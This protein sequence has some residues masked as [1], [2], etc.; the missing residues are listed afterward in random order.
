LIAL[1]LQRLDKVGQFSALIVR[2]SQFLSHF[3]PQ[4]FLSLQGRFELH[5]A[6]G[7]LADR[8]EGLILVELD[9]GL[10]LAAGVTLGI[11]DLLRL[12][13]QV[14]HCLVHRVKLRDQVVYHTVLRLE[15]LIEVMQ[16]CL[17]IDR[18][19]ETHQLVLAH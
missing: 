8:E 11:A 19:I 1:C 16:Q 14:L 10:E 4:F 12:A 18:R 15:L 3:N 6:R 13:V 7:D 2:D 9:R 17:A 5:D